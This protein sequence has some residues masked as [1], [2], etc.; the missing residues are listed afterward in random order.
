MSLYLSGLLALTF[1]FPHPLLLLCP[2]FFQFLSTS[3]L[4]LIRGTP[5][6]WR[7]IPVW[8]S[9]SFMSWEDTLAS[10]ASSL[11]SAQI[12][13]SALRLCRLSL[14]PPHLSSLYSACV[15]TLLIF[16]FH[17]EDPLVLPRTWLTPRKLVF[18]RH[19]H[20][21]V[22]PS[23]GVE[24]STEALTA[25]SLCRMLWIIV[26]SPTRKVTSVERTA[27]SQCNALW[28]KKI[29]RLEPL[30]KTFSVFKTS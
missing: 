23:P 29:G 2:C 10:V 7:I 21:G 24:S 26:R 8:S 12:P 3:F 27:D 14:A 1:N 20:Q 18:R 22:D 4:V 5:Q 13:A 16:L 15:F 28:L 11:S 6:R 25:A 30:W 17:Y 19:K 9:E